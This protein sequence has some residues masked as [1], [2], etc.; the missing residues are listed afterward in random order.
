M[1]RVQ[2]GHLRDHASEYVRRV[3]AGETIVIL[4]RTRPVAKLVPFAPEASGRRLLGSLRGSA[5]AVG[6]LEAPIAAPEQWFRG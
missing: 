5:Q 2:I 4:N 3:S 1:T 6:D